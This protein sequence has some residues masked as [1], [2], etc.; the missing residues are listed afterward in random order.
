[1]ELT[2]LLKSHLHSGV[3]K[4]FNFLPQGF[5]F[6][7]R[8]HGENAANDSQ[9]LNVVLFGIGSLLQILGDGTESSN[10]VLVQSRDGK[11]AGDV[12]IDQVGL[13]GTA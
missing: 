9:T 4:G 3:V 12:S 5:K 1:L 10:N 11:G 6:I 13:S 8:E 7:Q 2:F